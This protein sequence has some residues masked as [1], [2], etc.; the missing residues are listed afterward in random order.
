MKEYLMVI[1]QH[2]PMNVRSSNNVETSQ[3]AV[4]VIP[5]KRFGEEISKVIRRGELF[6]NDPLRLD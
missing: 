3:K 2:S 4:M 5:S 1:F 6:K